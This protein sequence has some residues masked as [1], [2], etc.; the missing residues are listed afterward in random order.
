MPYAVKWRPLSNPCMRQQD[1]VI[2]NSC[3]PK[4]PILLTKLSS[5]LQIRPALTWA[6]WLKGSY[7]LNSTWAFLNS[8]LPLAFAHR[9]VHLDVPENTW[10]SFSAAAKLGYKYIETDVRGTADGKV[11][12]CHDARACRLANLGA[13]ISSLTLS[14]LRSAA[15][16][17]GSED[18]PLLSDVLD[19][20]P[21]LRFNVDVKDKLA[22]DLVPDI[23]RRTDAYDRICIASFSETRIRHV[24]AR[25]DRAVCTGAPVIE[26][27]RFLAQPGRFAG[28]SQPAVLQLPLSMKGIPLVTSN[29][30]RKAHQVGIPV[31][32]W[33]LND[34]R[35][36]QAAI[37]LEV[38]GIMTDEPIL[39]KKELA[40]H[41]LWH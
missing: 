24:R 40:R 30:I 32:V 5:F 7:L 26:C 3:G 41:G 4:A 16:A 36:I 28:I 15:A 6:N 17:V 1:G 19:G 13:R 14:A 25:L 31:H 29:L 12:I 2:P 18:I 27:L 39:L 20:F 34:T 22:A 33:T 8:P 21:Q 10:L 9:G 11:I 35:S 37:R 23:V 38:D